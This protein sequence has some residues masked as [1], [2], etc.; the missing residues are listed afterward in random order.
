MS[1]TI[2][3]TYMVDGFVVQEVGRN[4][5]LDDLLEYL[6]AEV[7][8]G[9]LLS[10]LGGDDNGIDAKGDGSSAILLVLNSDL[11]LRVGTEP[12][13]STAATGNGHRRVELVCKHDGEGHELWGLVRSIAEHDTLITSTVILEAPMVQALSNIRGLL[14]N[15]DEDVA[16]LVVEAL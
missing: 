4:D 16:R 11:G 14:F 15:S 2:D 9:D 12:W 10:V 5:L 8:G 7:L 6:L 3:N 13:K 1:S